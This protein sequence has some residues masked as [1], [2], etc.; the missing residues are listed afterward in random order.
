MLGFEMILTAATG[1]ETGA[2]SESG[3][4][5]EG[6]EVRMEDSPDWSDDRMEVN[7]VCSCEFVDDVASE[8]GVDVDVDDEDDASGMM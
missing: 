6:D 1:E 4:S 3:S 7:V 5:D 2:E 8:A